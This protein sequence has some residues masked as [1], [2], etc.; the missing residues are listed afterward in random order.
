[1]FNIFEENNLIFPFNYN[2]YDLLSFDSIPGKDD[3]SKVIEEKNT[4]NFSKE[5]ILIPKIFILEKGNT[6]PEINNNKNNL[7]NG[8]YYTFEKIQKIFKDCKNFDF[9]IILKNFKEESITKLKERIKN[10]IYKRKNFIKNEKNI[11]DNKIN[12]KRGRKKRNDISKRIHNKFA[13]DNIIKKIKV[14]LIKYL[15]IFCNN[16]LKEL[17]L[18]IVL[19]NMN[20]NI[21]KNINKKK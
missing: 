3:D 5:K 10:R 17:N 15:T 13:S 11:S 14:K 18:N 7:T 6:S 9:N 8:L 2:I 4:L 16:I 19:K 21:V 12:F 1:M 20:N